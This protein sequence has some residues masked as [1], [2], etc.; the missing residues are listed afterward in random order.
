MVKAAFTKETDF[1]AQ[2]GI[3]WIDDAEVGEV[4]AAGPAKDM[5]DVVTH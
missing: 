2:A 5:D 1:F 4:P 3:E